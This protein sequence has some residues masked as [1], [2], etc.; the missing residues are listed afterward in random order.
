MPLRRV[1][2]S[3]VNASTPNPFIDSLVRTSRC[4]TSFILSVARVRHFV[5]WQVDSLLDHCP[6]VRAWV[7]R[8]PSAPPRTASGVT[9]TP[10][11]GCLL[12]RRKAYWRCVL[13]ISAVVATNG[14][15]LEHLGSLPRHFKFPAS[16][17]GCNTVS[18]GMLLAL[19]DRPCLC[20]GC[21]QTRHRRLFSRRFL[22]IS[23]DYSPLF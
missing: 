21:P 22:S 9:P 5:V 10:L 3:A 20:A 23:F 1:G 16:R 11:E 19:R 13:R 17:H 4:V 8:S 12:E 6:N 2:L 18:A 14:V 15:F 7:V